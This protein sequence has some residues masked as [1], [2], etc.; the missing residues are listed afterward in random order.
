MAFDKTKFATALNIPLLVK[1]AIAL[2]ERTTGTTNTLRNQVLANRT[3]DQILDAMKAATADADMHAVLDQVKADPALAQSFQDA[4]VKDPTM[5]DGLETIANA[6]ASGFGMGDL[7][8]LLAD[9][10]QRELMGKILDKVADGSTDGSGVDISFDHLQ[11]LLDAHKKGDKRAM[12]LLMQDMGVI[13]NI[14]MKEF[15]EFFMEFIQDPERATQKLVE[16][17]ENEGIITNA[18]AVEIRAILPEIGGAMKFMVEPYRQLTIDHPNAFNSIARLA[19]IASQTPPVG[20]RDKYNTSAVTG[21]VQGT[22]QDIGNRVV[23][24]S[25][26]VSVSGGQDVINRF[27]SVDA[28]LQP[29]FFDATKHQAALDHFNEIARDGVIDVAEG[30]AYGQ[31]YVKMRDEGWSAE[32]AFGLG[33]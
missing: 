31:A 13:G 28:Q 6:P 33:P 30:Q 29:I 27:L 18:Q 4:L 8:A 1:G 32:R 11:K 23:P 7:K 10:E 17:L 14:D 15:L 3:P 26:G 16:K 25:T 22:A 21:N 5:L 19:E 9:P 2:E 20:P 12:F 24:N